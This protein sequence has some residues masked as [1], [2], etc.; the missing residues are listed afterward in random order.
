MTTLSVERHDG[1]AELRDV[2]RRFIADRDGVGQARR[3]LEG[4]P[5]DAVTWTTMADQLGLPG[6]M[7]PEEHGGAGAGWPEM[8]V[9]LEEM[10]RAVLPSAY[11]ATVLATSAISAVDDPVLHAE[12]L[13]ALASGRTTAALAVL[14]DDARWDVGGVRLAASRDGAGH[15]LD[16]TKSFVLDGHTADVIVVAAR[17]DA[18]PSLFLVDGDSPGL[19]RTPT[20]G[21][22]PT[23]PHARLEF[24]S[25]PARLLGTEG[26][27]ARLLRHTFDAAVLAAAALAL[28]GADRCLELSLAYARER[29]AF[30]RPIGGFQA[31]KHKLADLYLEVEFARAAVEA[32]AE[33]AEADPGSL[34]TLASIALAQAAETYAVVATE[35]VHLHGGV[36]FTW[37]HDAQLFFRR[38]KSLQVLFGDA[39]LHLERV[40]VDL[41]DG[42]D[43]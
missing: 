3:A 36:G 16:G 25:V 7:M 10:G 31:V 29:V 19:T 13:P 33:G 6:L 43:A 15:L 20:R 27:G 41:I 40:A 8:A 39:A 38:A 2:V 18:G 35:T 11:L 5:Y 14:E 30:G 37:E 21:L 28:G 22:D 17:S 34:S 12:L 42:G 32:A 1:L 23:L 24:S 4:H 26:Q 9:V